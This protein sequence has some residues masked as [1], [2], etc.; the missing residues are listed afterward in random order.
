MEPRRLP[1]EETRKVL[2]IK[3]FALFVRF[4]QE[5]GTSEV[6]K[7]QDTK[8]KKNFNYTNFISIRV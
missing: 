8:M 7:S 2:V 6:N 1:L 4:G 5:H 3:D